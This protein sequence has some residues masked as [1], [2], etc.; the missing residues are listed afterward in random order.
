MGK[1]FRWLD[2]DDDL[3]DDRAEPSRPP[4]PDD[5]SSPASILRRRQD[6]PVEE[7]DSRLQALRAKALSAAD[8]KT[9][10]PQT[11]YDVDDVLVSP[12]IAHRPSGV[13]SAAALSQAQKKQVE[14]L[15]D[16]VGG[17]LEADARAE[18]RRGLLSILAWPRLLTALIIFAAVT[19]PFVLLNIA[20]GDLPP[21][22]FGADNPAAEQVF[23]ALDGLQE[24][25]WA[26]VGY[27]YGPTAAGELDALADILLRHLFFRGAK[28]II[29]SSNPIALVHARNVLNDISRSVQSAGMSLQANRDYYLLRYLAGGALGL[30]DLSHNFAS[31]VNISA[32]GFPTHLELTS[33]DEMALI[34]LIA[35]RADDIRH[36]AEQV[37]PPTTVD[38]VAA[39]G[40]A[41]Q[42]LAEPYALQSAGIS[43]L[44]VGVRGAYTYGLM[45]QDRLPTSPE[46]LEAF[47]LLPPAAGETP[48]PTVTAPPTVTPQ[49]NATPQPTASPTTAPN[50][51]AYVQ[52]RARRQ[53]TPRLQAITLGT[54]AAALIIAFGNAYFGLQALLRR[55]TKSKGQ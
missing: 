54:M 20:P 1:D 39:T 46:D 35:E 16:I 42:P 9:A 37:A 52:S 30:R 21:P 47:D 15:Q 53:E 32:R 27:E 10:P 33:L 55:R 31:I 25:D 40:Y 23:A 8:P 51:A 12:E 18:P 5:E 22:T 28:P 38:L 11:L 36:W 34:L 4:Q 17:P 14:L 44:L 50:L 2:D 29:V 13:I 24:G 6:R 48:L 7:L 49:P 45:L 19:A 41:A 43:G 3:G 26:L